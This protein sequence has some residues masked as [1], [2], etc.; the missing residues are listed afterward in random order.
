[1]LLPNGAALSRSIGLLLCVRDQ[2]ADGF[3]LKSRGKAII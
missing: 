3:A 2:R 1:V